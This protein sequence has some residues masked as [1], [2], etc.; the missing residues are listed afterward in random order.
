[1]IW[2]HLPKEA[3]AVLYQGE[4]VG[5][6]TAKHMDLPG[7][8]NILYLCAS[9]AIEGLRAYNGDPADFPVVFNCMPAVVGAAMQ[10]SDNKT[11]GQWA[12]ELTPTQWI[13]RALT[14]P[15]F[16]L[17]AVYPL[18]E[19]IAREAA[20]T[21]VPKSHNNLYVVDFGARRLVQ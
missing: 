6:G 10:V 5:P 2:S 4:M 16:I 15:N 18:W 20:A 12:E 9:Q 21:Y 19:M 14:V 17:A 11:L 1:M 8:W 13:D 3:Y 7:M